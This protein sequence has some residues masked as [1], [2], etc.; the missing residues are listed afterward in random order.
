MKKE[1]TRQQKIDAIYEKIADKTLSFGCKL[2]LKKDLDYF[3]KSWIVINNFNW[4]DALISY[5]DWQIK[6]I[7]LESDIEEIIWHPVMIWDILDYIDKNCFYYQVEEWRYER[8]LK[9]LH[10]CIIALYNYFIWNYRNT[11]E[12]LDNDGIDFIYNLIK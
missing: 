2:I 8:D 3:W 1:L 10:E 6:D 7:D 5:W 9:E 11:I 12:K 4:E